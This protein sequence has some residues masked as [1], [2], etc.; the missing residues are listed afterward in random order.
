MLRIVCIL[1]GPL[2]LVSAYAIFAGWG[3]SLKGVVNLTPGVAKLTWAT[4]ALMGLALL[5][6]GIWMLKIGV[7]TI[8]IDSNGITVP[9]SMMSKDMIHVPFAAIRG[10]NVTEY[11]GAEML[12]ITHGDRQTK[13]ESPHFESFEAFTELTDRLHDAVHSGT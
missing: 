10:L 2:V 3:L 9:A 13:L 1:G 12:H 6:W 11:N 8:E 5:G 4:L 7:R